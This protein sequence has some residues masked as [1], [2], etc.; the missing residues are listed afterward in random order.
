MGGSKKRRAHHD[1]VFI[2]SKKSEFV[3]VWRTLSIRN[4]MASIV[5][6]GLRM[7]RRTYIFLR[8]SGSTSSSSLRVPDLV[9]SSAGKMRLSATLRSRMISELPVP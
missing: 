8:I 5:P 1:Q 3:L 4:S 9:M 7:R 2:E 6:I